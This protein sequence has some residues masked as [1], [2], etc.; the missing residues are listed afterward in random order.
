MREIRANKGGS[1]FCERRGACYGPSRGGEKKPPNGP[2]KAGEGCRFKDGPVHK[3]ERRQTKKQWG[4]EKQKTFH[5][6]TGKR[7]PFGMIRGA[8]VGTG[9]VTKNNDGESNGIDMLRLTKGKTG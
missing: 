7:K 9:Q 8:T 4:G 3:N 2:E 1:S 6:G 5:V